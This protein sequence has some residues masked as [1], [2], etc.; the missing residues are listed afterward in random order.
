V[1]LLDVPFITR[2]AFEE[3]MVRFVEAGFPL[4]PRFRLRWGDPL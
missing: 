3:A 1:A 4:H 2:E